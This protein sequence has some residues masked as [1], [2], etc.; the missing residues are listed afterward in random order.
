MNLDVNL[1]NYV[2]CRF[3]TLQ[4]DLFEITVDLAVGYTLEAALDH[5]PKFSVS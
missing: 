4:H 2:N 5:V 3:I 1:S